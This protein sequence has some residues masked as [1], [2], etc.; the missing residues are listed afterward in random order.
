MGEDDLSRE[1]NDL[2]R[3]LNADELGQLRVG[4]CIAIV[5]WLDGSR[6]LL[7][8]PLVIMAIRAPFIAVVTVF[9]PAFRGS[10]DTRAVTLMRM[11]AAYV[12]ALRGPDPASRLQ[13]VA[14]A[15]TA[16]LAALKAVVRR[17]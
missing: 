5:D 11:D 1:L 6:V 16:L 4:E 15:W 13:A 9:G 10:L 12:S 7:G 14:H 8:I 2:V 17:G 3:A